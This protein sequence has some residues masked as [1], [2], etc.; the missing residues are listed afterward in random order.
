MVELTQSSPRI[1]VDYVDGHTAIAHR[2]ELRLGAEAIS[3]LPPDAP[4]IIWPYIDV[5]RMP[6]QAGRTG[7][8]LAKGDGPARLYIPANQY[9]LSDALRAACPPRNDTPAAKQL[10]KKLFGF[11]LLAIGSVILILFFLLPLMAIQLA[12]VLPAEGEKALGDA[13]FEQVRVALDDFGDT[14]LRVCDDLAGRKALDVMAARLLKH[15]DLPFPATIHVLD[16][17]LVNAFALPGGH[18]VLF[19][20]LLNAADTPDEVA[21]VLAHELGHVYYRHATEGALRS[22]GSIGVLGLLFG[23]FAG[24]TVALFLADQLINARYSQDA[25]TQ[26]DEFAHELLLD[27][28]ISPAALAV[29]F[30]RLKDMSGEQSGLAAHL[31]SHPELQA[32][33][34]AA[35]AVVPGETALFAPS[36][37]AGQWQNL[38]R[39]CK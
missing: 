9:E 16:S 3:I 29:F 15:V 33:M 31:S 26:A 39:I 35:L 30:Q 6:D 12:R 11:S 14:G 20:G 27:A 18:V 32:R 28:Q 4:A 23:D 22:A 38:K 5:H 17:E 19:R 7:M 25:E 37:S 34:D 21:A 24:G 2:V 8:V 1:F 36:L 10:R 13:T